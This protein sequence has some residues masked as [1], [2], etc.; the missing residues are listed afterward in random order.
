MSKKYYNVQVLH[1]Q[2]IWNFSIS[3]LKGNFVGV[4]RLAKNSLYQFKLL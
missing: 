4:F 1:D 3:K 2:Q